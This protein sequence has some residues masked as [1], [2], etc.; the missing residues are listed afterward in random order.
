MTPLQK[1]IAHLRDLI[2]ETGHSIH[3]VLRDDIRSVCKAAERTEQQPP[4]VFPD[5]TAPNY[6]RLDRH[7]PVRR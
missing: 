4:F 1:S 7:P 5:S 2:R 6:H 3:P